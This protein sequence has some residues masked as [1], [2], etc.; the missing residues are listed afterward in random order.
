MSRACWKKKDGFDEGSQKLYI[1]SIQAI[2]SQ[3]H[4]VERIE[5]TNIKSTNE[6]LNCGRLRSVCVCCGA[7]GEVGGKRGMHG[8]NFDTP[9]LFLWRLCSQT[10]DPPH[11]WHWLLLRSCSRQSTPRIVCKSFFRG[12]VRGE[13]ITHH[14]PSSPYYSE[15]VHTLILPQD[16]CKILVLFTNL[17]QYK[18]L[19]CSVHDSSQSVFH[20]RSWQDLLTRLG[21]EFTPSPFRVSTR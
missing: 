19:F 14:I 15:D 20:S 11:C 13:Y 1:Q 5:K 2:H 21:L 7:S 6:C 9:P 12:C 8:K 16:I 17:R 3:K 10:T 4:S 18:I